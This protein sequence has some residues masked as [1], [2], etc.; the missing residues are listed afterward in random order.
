MVSV[1]SSVF[2]YGGDVVRFWGSRRI[3]R[4]TARSDHLGP[5]LGRWDGP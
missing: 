4:V 1:D 3:M 5:E 2:D